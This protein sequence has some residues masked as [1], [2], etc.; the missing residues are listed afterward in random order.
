MPVCS[1][2]LT[3]PFPLEF[4][5]VAWMRDDTKETE[6]GFTR[7]RMKIRQVKKSKAKE[8]INLLSVYVKGIRDKNKNY[9]QR[10]FLSRESK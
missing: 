2:L 5:F 10:N 3:I 7:M 1:S 8:F 6:C 9:A 4:F